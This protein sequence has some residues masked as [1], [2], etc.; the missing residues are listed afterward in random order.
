[1]LFFFPFFYNWLIDLR[2]HLDSVHLGNKVHSCSY[3][4]KAFK[5]K[6]SLRHHVQVQVWSTRPPLWATKFVQLRHMLQKVQLFIIQVIAFLNK[7]SLIYRVLVKAVLLSVMSTLK[8]LEKFVQCSYRH[9]PEV[10][11]SVQFT[12]W[13]R[14][15]VVT[16]VRYIQRYIY[17]YRLEVMIFIHSTTPFHFFYFPGTHRCKTFQL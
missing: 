12:H 10:M 8:Q 7:T 5:D 15:E 2:R 13:Y 9:K 14:A 1:M 16:F 17:R 6:T 4:T 3:C 11:I